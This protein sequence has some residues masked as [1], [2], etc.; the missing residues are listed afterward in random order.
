MP[1]TRTLSVSIDRPWQSLYET[2]WRPE[3]FP[4]WASGLSQSNLERRGERWH[5]VGPEGPIAIT[6]TEHNAFGVMD[7]WVEL[8][9]GQDIYIPLRI[10]AN[11]SGAEVQLTLFRQPG[12]SDEAFAADQ[13]WVQR[14]L[15]ALKT[16]SER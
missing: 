9:D 12:M 13:A 16:L 6:F 14:D 3:T 10:I 15:L 1:E 8:G 11:G 4:Q 2:W 7:H 5:A